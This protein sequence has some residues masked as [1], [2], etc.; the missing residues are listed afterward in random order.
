MTT[1][2]K[3]SKN[4]LKEKFNAREF[5]SFVLEKA[6][7]SITDTVVTVMVLAFMLYF[8]NQLLPAHVSG[9]F[10]GL[11]ITGMLIQLL[12]R[13]VHRFDDGYTVDELAERMLEMEHSIKTDLNSIRQDIAD[14]AVV[15]VE[16]VP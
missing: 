1:L 6:A 2:V 10:T 11:L 15:E 9:P 3:T 5:I 4:E 13:I 14:I 7:D 8:T 12:I 16:R